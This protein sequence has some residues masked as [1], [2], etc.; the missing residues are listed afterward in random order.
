M[1]DQVTKVIKQGSISYQIKECVLN[2][3]DK[4]QVFTK[5]G[6]NISLDIEIYPNYFLA[7]FDYF[8][9]GK[10]Y[11]EVRGNKLVSNDTINKKQLRWM[12]ENN[13]NYTFNG[14]NYDI[15]IIMC[16]LTND[17]TTEEIHNLSCA[18]IE[19]GWPY[20]TLKRQGIKSYDFNFNHVDLIELP[21]G[22][23][24]LKTYAGRIHAPYMQDLPYRFDTV[25][26]TEQ[27]DNVLKYCWNDTGNTILLAKSLSKQLELR[28]EMSFKY[29]V[30][31]NSKSDAQIAEAVIGR[32]L[33]WEYGIQA[34]KPNLKKYEDYSFKYNIP[35]NIS[36]KTKEM[37]RVLEVIRD[38][39]FELKNF[40]PVMP[41][42]IKDLNIKIGS[43]E[44]T[45]G[46]G[47]LHSTEENLFVCSNDEFDLYDRDVTS[48]YPSIILNQRLY[49]K[50]LGSSFLS[51]Y[52]GIVDARINAKRSG[53]KTTAD[54]LKITING[55]FGKFGNA[56]SI[57]FSPELLIQTTV[58]GQLYLLMAIEALEVEGF[59]VISGNTDGFVTKVPK[60][61][62]DRF[63][64]IMSDWEKQ[65]DFQLEEAYYKKYFAL[66]VNNYIAVGEDNKPKRKGCFAE[67]SLGKNP[68]GSIIYDSICEYVVNG[69]PLAHTIESCSDFTKFLFVRKVKGGCIDQDGNEVG[70]VIRWYYD[71]SEF[72]PL[73]YKINRNKVPVSDGARVFMDLTVDIPDTICYGR[74]LHD[75]QKLL[76]QVETKTEQLSL[77]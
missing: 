28:R 63:D 75:A 10:V 71:H 38:A 48:Y 23:A 52:K 61:K 26:D 74:Y 30:D 11:F 67:S 39:E 62:K 14:K 4:K 25:L 56:Y 40:K 58:S 36:F 2:L 72:C 16:I 64:Q 31:L 45:I 19:D 35:D 33:E 20:N 77:I 41:Q 43:T 24:S 8:E 5:A 60:G 22:K 29:Q 42:S 15:P 18:I 44:Y 51:V 27:M 59:S 54:S 50:Q 37:Q 12:L 53:D 69:T 17:Y 1:L 57:L 3:L 47:G 46:I 32:Q 66:N 65:T 49:P 9:G 70:T 34:S 76:N 6:S 7:C 68:A 55:S 13:R 73:R 21:I